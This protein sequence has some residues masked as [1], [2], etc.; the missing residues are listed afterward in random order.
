VNPKKPVTGYGVGS[1]QHQ[2]AHGHVAQTR[3][4]AAENDA[5]ADQPAGRER[6]DGK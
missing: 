1:I 3:H 2:N 4:R 6:M 5:A